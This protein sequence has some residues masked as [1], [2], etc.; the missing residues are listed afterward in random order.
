MK[1]Q[2][3]MQPLCV[4]TVSTLQC[5]TIQ[6]SLQMNVLTQD[7][8]QNIYLQNGIVLEHQLTGAASIQLSG[9]ISI[10]LWN[11]DAHSVIRNRYR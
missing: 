1:Y 5:L 6:L 4:C 10:S 8:K 3:A 2:K 11:Q 9:F 7:K